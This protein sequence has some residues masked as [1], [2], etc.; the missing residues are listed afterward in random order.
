MAVEPELRDYLLPFLDTEDPIVLR[1]RHEP[2]LASARLLVSL[3][4][5]WIVDEHAPPCVK[6]CG[7]PECRVSP[8]AHELLRTELCVKPGCPREAATGSDTCTECAPRAYPSAPHEQV[9]G[10]PYGS[11]TPERLQLAEQVKALRDD[12]FTHTEVAA[13]LGISRSYA[14]CLAIDPDGSQVRARKD[15]YRQP[16]PHCGEPMTGTFGRTR[17]PT[18]CAKCALA[19]QHEDR[20]WTPEEV[21]AAFQTFHERFGRSPGAA[22]AMGL[23]ASTRDKWSPERAREIEA[24]RA[25][26]LL[27]IPSTVQREFGSWAAALTA[28]GLDQN[29]TGGAA[30]RQLRLGPAQ[31]ATLEILATG[32]Q[33][34]T[35]IAAARGIDASTAGQCLYSLVAR[36]LVEKTERGLYQLTGEPDTSQEGA[37]PMGSDYVVLTRTPDGHYEK[38]DTVQAIT[39]GQAIEKVAD[40]VGCYVAVLARNWHEHDVA[41]KTVFAIVEAVA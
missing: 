1:L 29:P 10:L 19:A 36:G 16:C 35:Q 41:P 17:Q 8:S 33:R 26:R 38:A 39:P 6:H 20:H 22:D 37:A 18:M 23:H 27:P 34:V 13:R 31:R 11:V 3:G 28:A 9:G 25:E 2:H 24:A 14:S 40:G 12:G 30:H 7:R 4:A 5:G 21:I 15:S 32:P